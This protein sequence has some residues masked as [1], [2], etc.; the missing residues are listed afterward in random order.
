[1]MPAAFVCL[2]ALAAFASVAAPFLFRDAATAWGLTRPVIYGGETRQEFILESTGAGVAVFDYDRDG[3]PDI[4]LVN[5]S[6]LEGFGKGPA[7]ISMLYRNVGGRFVDV[8]EKSGLG[9]HGWGQGVCA[10]DYDN[11]GWTDLY[12]TYYG[13]NVLYRNRGDGTFE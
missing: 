8:T 1:M 6:R 9:R 5:G 10:G 2:V 7:P 11:D 12:V 3:R 13:R 4:F